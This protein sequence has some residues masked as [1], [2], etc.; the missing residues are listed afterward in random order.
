MTL[1]RVGVNIDQNFTNANISSYLSDKLRENDPLD[2][3]FTYLAE[4]ETL[5]S[6][7]AAE[8]DGLHAWFG[9]IIIAEDADQLATAEAQAAREASGDTELYPP[10]TTKTEEVT[11]AAVAWARA[12]GGEKKATDSKYARICN[13]RF[14]RLYFL[15]LSRLPAHFRATKDLVM[16]TV[17][18]RQ[19]DCMGVS[20]CYL[21]LLIDSN[22]LLQL[23]ARRKHHRY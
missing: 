9:K 16:A 22:M 4:N 23:S 19:K 20:H 13:C 14:A 2:L 1:V 12:Y 21:I 3:C 18:G 17:T 5:P 11:Q 7:R 10:I 6:T 15:T 8:E